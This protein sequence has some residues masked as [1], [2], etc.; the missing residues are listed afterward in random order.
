M[1]NTGPVTIV[2]GVPRSGTSLLM[3]MLAAGGMPILT[4]GVRAADIDNPRGYLE[5]EPVKNT[6]ND[7]SWLEKA[8]GHAV[9]MVYA[10]IYDL[11]STFNN[12]VILVRRD[13]S[14]A[15]ASQRAMLERLGRTGSKLPD[16]RV[17]ALFEREMA[18]IK[19]WI[20]KQPNFRLMELD[21][22]DCVYNPAAV[23]EALSSFLGGR[24]DQLQMAKAAEPS[25][26]RKKKA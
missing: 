15:I 21:F 7:P 18:A 11:P 17:A 1:L 16:D 24:L 25:L 10:L 3:Q 22:R 2:A 12:R 26:H 8:G 19:Q 5:F 20:A 14:E 4:D 13:L 9:K 6:R 23:A